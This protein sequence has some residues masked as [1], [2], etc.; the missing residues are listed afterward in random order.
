MNMMKSE[1]ALGNL[2]LARARFRAEREKARA[3]AVEIASIERR[4]SALQPGDPEHFRAT[5]KLRHRQE[6]MSRAS[7]FSFEDD[8]E[9]R[10]DALLQACFQ[11]LIDAC[12]NGISIHYSGGGNGNGGSSS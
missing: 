12:R 11:D 6:E 5:D 4:L 7:L 2:V 1:Q 3:L 9:D 10:R 8:V